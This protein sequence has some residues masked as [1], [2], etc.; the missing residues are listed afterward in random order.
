M[1]AESLVKGARPANCTLTIAL[2]GFSVWLEGSSASVTTQRGNEPCQL[3]S[4]DPC[5]YGSGRTFRPEGPVDMARMKPPL[6][7]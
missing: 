5:T 2:S 4:R 6:L 1:N 3:K 7:L